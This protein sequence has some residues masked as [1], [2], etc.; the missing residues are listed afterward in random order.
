MA[1]AAAVIV[2]CLSVLFLPPHRCEVAAPSSP[3][4]QTVELDS[5]GSTAS[6]TSECGTDLVGQCL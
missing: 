4:V 5:S 2:V 3:A 1:V 6:A